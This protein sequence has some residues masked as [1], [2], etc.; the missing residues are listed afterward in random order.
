MSLHITT[1]Q[2]RRKEKAEKCRMTPKYKVVAASTSVM[3]TKEEKLGTE[4]NTKENFFGSLVI[5][6]YSRSK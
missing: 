6:S 5:R 3:A 2:R 1:K 4:P